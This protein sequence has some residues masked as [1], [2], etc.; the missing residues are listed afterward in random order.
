MNNAIKKLK[1][2]FFKAIHYFVMIG[3]VL[4]YKCRYR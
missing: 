2:T 3:I 1:D 4:A